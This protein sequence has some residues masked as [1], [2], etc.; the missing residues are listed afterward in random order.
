VGLLILD[1]L[2]GS[3]VT[4]RVITVSGLAQPGAPITQDVPLWFDNHTT[5]DAA[6]QWSFTVELNVGWNALRFRVGDDVATQ[7]TL[8]VFF[9]R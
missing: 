3:T 2:E 1:P 6:G 7:V 8:N 9:A 4:E 5:A